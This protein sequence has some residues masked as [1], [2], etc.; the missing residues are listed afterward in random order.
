MLHRKYSLPRGEMDFRELNRQ[1]VG[2]VVSS[3]PVTQ[4]MRIETDNQS[5]PRRCDLR[6]NFNDVAELRFKS[7]DC[8][9]RAIHGSANEYQGIG[10]GAASEGRKFE[11]FGPVQIRIPARGP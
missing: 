9:V 1:V 6:Q 2:Q 11:G 5:L 10:S 7:P 8:S 4:K 3:V